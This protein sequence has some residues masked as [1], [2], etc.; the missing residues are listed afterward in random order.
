MTAAPRRL[1]HHKSTR[2]RTSGRRS[3]RRYLERRITRDW[4]VPLSAD[5][6]EMD[7]GWRCISIRPTDDDAW[8]IVD[9]SRDY[10]TEW[11]RWI[12]L[13]DVEGEA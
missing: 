13:D 9:S 4:K 12:D 8:F 6:E 2:G 1:P 5:D 7:S 10:K 3:L 11:G